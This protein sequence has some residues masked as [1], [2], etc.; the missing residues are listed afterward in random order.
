MKRFGIVTLVLVI[1]VSMFGLTGCFN[2]GADGNV[3]E[4]IDPNIGIDDPAQE[5]QQDI[6]VGSGT[7]VGQIDNNSVEIIISGAPEEMAS[8]AFRL[9]PE[10]RERFDQLGLQDNSPVKFE[11]YVDNQDQWMLVNIGPM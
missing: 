8:R 1:A 9:S 5:E 4:I 7:Y 2:S 10:V 6:K 3:P 11:Y